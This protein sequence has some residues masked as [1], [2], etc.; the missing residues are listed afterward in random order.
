MKTVLAV[1]LGGTN[2][3]MAAVSQDGR[4]LHH[5][6][7]PTPN[8]LAPDDL[9][10]L[11][12]QLADDCRWPAS[13]MS[14]IAFAPPANVG[15]DGIIRNLPNIPLLDGFG[16]RDALQARFKVPAVVEN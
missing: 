11:T 6:K 12:G 3:R 15:G 14:A 9:L 7:R 13:S 10:E 16:L 5:T 2:I 4:I 1:D 8:D